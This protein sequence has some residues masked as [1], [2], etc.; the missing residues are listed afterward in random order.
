M[1]VF[2]CWYYRQIQRFLDRV[3]AHL[4]ELPEHKIGQPY[5]ALIGK[6]GWPRVDIGWSLP[7]TRQEFPHPVTP[8]RTKLI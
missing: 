4:R 6:A 2:L 8:F 5:P 3:A 7:V 1:T